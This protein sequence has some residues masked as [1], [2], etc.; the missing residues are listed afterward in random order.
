[1]EGERIEDQGEEERKAGP[2]VGLIGQE[3]EFPSRIE[4]GGRIACRQGEAGRRIK[5]AV[6]EPRRVA[7]VIG[8]AALGCGGCDPGL[9]NCLV[10]IFRGSNLFG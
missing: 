5:V 6:G 3:G 1:M 4:G 8:A 2:L 10:C 9:S 7:Q